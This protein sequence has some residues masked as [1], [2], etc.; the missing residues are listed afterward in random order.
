MEIVAGVLD[1]DEKPEDVARRE[2]WKKQAAKS[3][4]FIQFAS[5]L[6]AP[7]GHNEYLCFF[8]AG[9]MP[10]NAGG[11]H[12][13]ED[14]NEDIRAFTVPVDEAFIMLQEGKIKTSPAIISLQW[15]QLNREWLKQLWQTK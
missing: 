2:A 4:I 7:A 15:L 9:S 6:S 10:S 12:G 3:W 8:V 5:I 1:S 14:E 11:I 13:L